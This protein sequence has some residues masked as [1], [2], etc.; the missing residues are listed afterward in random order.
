MLILTFTQNNQTAGAECCRN[1]STIGQ[2]LALKKT[3]DSK[4]DCLFIW[5]LSADVR[6]GNYQ[7][8]KQL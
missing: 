1:I 4:K 2:E 7:V 6:R 5:V 3:E 8:I